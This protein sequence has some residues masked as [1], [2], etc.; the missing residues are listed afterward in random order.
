MMQRIFVACLLVYGCAAVT[1]EYRDEFTSATRSMAKMLTNE[2]L[3][4]G[5]TGNETIGLKTL[6]ATLAHSGQ[7]A[8]TEVEHMSTKD[9]S[10]VCTICRSAINVILDV[11]K[12]TNS[13]QTLKTILVEMCSKFKILEKEVCTNLFELNWPVWEYILSNKDHTVTDEGV[14]SVLLQASKCVTKEPQ[15]NWSVEIDSNAGK[16]TQSKPSQQSATDDDLVIVQISDIHFDPVYMTG[17]NAECTKPMC[18]SLDSNDPPHYAKAAGQWSDYR[19]C[20][21]PMRLVEASLLQI[22]NQHP[23]IDYIYYTGDIVDHAVWRTSKS[24]NTKSMQIIYGELKRVF[25]GVPVYSIIGNHESQPLNQFAPNNVPDEVSTKWLYNLLEVEWSK[26]ITNSSA[27]E[28]IKIGG[29]YTV[30][31]QEGFRIIAL[32]NNDCYTFNFWIFHDPSYLKKQL[33]WL[34]N[35][36]LAAEKAKE[37]VHIL[38]HVP[39][40]AGSCLNTWSREFRRIIERFHPI[41]GG[42][43]NGHTH[44][45]EF[46]VVYSIEKPQRAINV[47]WNGGSITPYSYVNPNYRVYKVE[48]KSYQVTE[49]DTWIFNLTA[50]NLSPDK[51]PTWFKEYSFRQAYGINDL[52][53]ASLDKLLGTFS[54]DH[55][56][57]KKYWEYKVKRGDPSLKMGCNQACLIKHLCQAATSQHNDQVRCDQLKVDYQRTLEGLPPVYKSAASH[58]KYSLQS[59]LFIVLFTLL[60]SVQYI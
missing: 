40:G 30:L 46:S 42:I 35:T 57:L 26:W 47:A 8:R 23:K 29:Y 12:E 37:H 13:K 16:I 25:G 33:Q 28:T 54:T 52:S 21:T 27:K 50:A 48:R 18:C 32:N 31:A 14:C 59:V 43:F 10:F 4:Y 11:I 22:K 56:L 6:V 55:E 9:Q 36:L 3:V 7:I 19:N 24:E 39:S 41:I 45:D 53:P 2:V 5:Q 49:H 44:K 58:L 17:S 51:N 15:Y 20:D 1:D 34:H 60:S 38:A